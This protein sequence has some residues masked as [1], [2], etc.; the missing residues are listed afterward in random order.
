MRKTVRV[1]LILTCVIITSWAQNSTA[2]EDDVM[3]WVDPARSREILDQ[4]EQLREV[5]RAG[6]RT[7][8]VDGID[9]RSDMFRIKGSD[10][11]DLVIFEDLFLTNLG[12][13]DR[14]EELFGRLVALGFPV[15][16]RRLLAKAWAM[17]FKTFV[18]RQLDAGSK[19]DKATMKALW[20]GQVL[21][22]FSP[23][24]Q[25]ALVALTVEIV[26]PT[27][28]IDVY[29]GSTTVPN[30]PEESR[31]QQTVLSRLDDWTDW[32]NDDLIVLTSA[33]ITCS[34]STRRST[35]T[36]TMEVDIPNNWIEDRIY[37]LI[38]QIFDFDAGIGVRPPNEQNYEMSTKG[39]SIADFNHSL[40]LDALNLVPGV[41]YIAKGRYTL[42]LHQVITSG[43]I[44]LAIIGSGGS[45]TIPTFDTVTRSA[46]FQGN[47]CQISENNDDSSPGNGGSG[48]NGGPGD[49]NIEP[50]EGVTCPIGHE[51]QN[52]NC[53]LVDDCVFVNCQPGYE[54][55]LGVCVQV[56]VN[57]P[58][59]P[60]I[61][62]DCQDFPRSR[63][64]LSDEMKALALGLAGGYLV[65]DI[66]NNGSIAGSHEILVG[67]P[68]EDG[69]ALETPMEALALFDL[70][71]Y[72]GDGDGAITPNDLIWQRL[73]IWYDL[74]E[75]GFSKYRELRFPENLGI[76]AIRVR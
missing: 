76:T 20:L 12:D 65:C 60:Q 41:G 9:F 48:N 23:Q 17:G 33:V 22:L 43:S 71:R 37:A 15:E 63:D 27:Y 26:L 29:V 72:G 39:F 21:G 7:G 54:C 14:G 50:C 24:A 6:T 56:V 68:G 31:Q 25:E 36:A 52:G 49:S 40:S 46:P 19:D 44:S 59:F 34:S 13:P 28:N 38:D 42:D 3:A 10:R 18:L 30:E 2:G 62:P 64:L 58:C 8:R 55:I 1:W 35:T 66:N 32:F 74:D 57:D 5:V 51:C 11:P 70:P 47:T 53:I 16:E 67:T 61:D 45:L 4:Y 75:N 73:R 69:R